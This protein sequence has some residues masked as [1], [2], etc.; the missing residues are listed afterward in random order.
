MLE[1]FRC[2]VKGHV[3]VDSRSQPGMQVCVRCRYREPFEGLGWAG[4]RPLRDNE[5]GGAASPPA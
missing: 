3:F 1:T 5:V 2:R 4:A